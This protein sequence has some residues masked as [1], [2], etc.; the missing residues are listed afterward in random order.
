MS[1]E[2]GRKIV[3]VGASGTVG[4][5]TLTALL[6]TGIHT[7][8]AVTRNE[9]SAT[10]PSGVQ[11]KKG[12][13]NDDSFLVSALKGHD[14]LILQLGI[15]Q[16]ELQVTLIEAAAKAGVPWV[17][18]TEFGSDINSPIA[19]DFEITG[20]KKKYR[21]L[22]E[23][24]GSSWVAIVNNPWF[25]WS[26]KAGL[27]SIDVPGKKATL[28]NVNDTKFNTS[29]LSQVGTAVARLL[30]LPDEKLNAY[31]NRSLYVRSFLV[32]QYD[33]FDSVVRATGTKESEWEVKMQKPEEAIEASR[34]AVAEGNMM[35][36][37]GEFYT[38]HMQAGRGGNYEE[39][40]VTD[41]ATIGLEKENLDEV[42]KRIVTDLAGN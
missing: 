4:S 8:T 6:K 40:A 2:K 10:F 24:K 36:F 3:M 34:K 39:K 37:V 13:Y 26:L 18:P 1:S 31:K 16:M 23:E 33:I 41:A 38:A 20:M 29:T 9:S 30:S 12:D 19:K 21:D 7:I 28:Y 32:S 15:M 17:L 25:D 11:V 27:W 14:V 22:I 35:A 42:V 5:P